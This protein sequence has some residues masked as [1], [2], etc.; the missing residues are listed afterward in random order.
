MVTAESVYLF[1]LFRHYKAGHLLNAGGIS[2]QPELYLNA[3]QIIE[4]ALDK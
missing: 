3:M 4:A 1:S 2:D